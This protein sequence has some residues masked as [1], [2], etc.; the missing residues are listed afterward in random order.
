MSG[1]TAAPPMIEGEIVRPAPP[2]AAAPV[3]EGVPDTLDE[4]VLVTILRDVRMV[5][6]K[7][8]VVLLPLGALRGG[9]AGAGGASAASARD[10]AGAGSAAAS[11]GSV[12]GALR[13]LREWDLWGPL[14]LCLA[15]SIILSLSAPAGQ[16][17]LVFASVFV[18]VWAGAAVITLNAYL[19]GGKISFF[20]S[21][22]VLGYCIF[23]LVLAA[24]ACY[25][26]ANAVLRG[27]AVAAALVWATR[28]SVVF[29][30]DLVDA[31][32]RTLAVYPVCLFYALLGWMVFIQ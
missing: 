8:R 25:L 9:T 24:L 7:L 23:P 32:K 3:A 4:P 21:L 14:V 16:S 29:M 2:P 27:L 13:E 31:P 22:C 6:R 11:D 26:V 17:A 12:N 15:L 10:D 19:L 1:A 30:S 20:Q 28:A 18:T 5:A